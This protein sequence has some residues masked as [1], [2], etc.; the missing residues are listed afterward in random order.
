MINL[1]TDAFTIS[2]FYYM[3]SLKSLQNE[4]FCGAAIIGAD[5][6][7][8]SAFCVQNRVVNDFKVTVRSTTDSET[9]FKPIEIV[10]HPS[11]GKDNSEDVIALIQVDKRFA[12]VNAMWRPIPLI[13]KDNEKLLQGG[14]LIMSG[15]GATAELSE[16][17]ILVYLH[18]TITS[19]ANCARIYKDNSESIFCIT[20]DNVD[21][22]ACAGDE[23][24]PLVTEDFKLAGII[25]KVGCGKKPDKAI[26]VSFFR[27]WIAEKVSTPRE[28]E[29]L[30]SND[31]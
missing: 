28:L 16:A 19:P 18:S 1:L 14:Q 6:V 12:T 24:G 15:Y 21:S 10:N 31:I 27:D 2:D 8:T 25:A 22:G 3:A 29:T 11:L 7:I 9:A 13:A 4:N 26:Q 23:G 17:V 20:G 30:E 5:Y